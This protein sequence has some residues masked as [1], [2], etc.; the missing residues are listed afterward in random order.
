MRDI[1]TA[2]DQHTTAF[3]I[4]ALFIFFI[5]DFIKDMIKK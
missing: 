4:L 5:L 1:L 2:I 3:I